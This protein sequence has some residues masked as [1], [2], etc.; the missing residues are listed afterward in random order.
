MKD[1]ELKLLDYG[2]FPQDPVIPTL[3]VMERS[4]Q[5]HLGVELIE[6]LVAEKDYKNAKKV[7]W[8]LF[9]SFNNDSYVL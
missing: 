4:R 6:K 1:K 2:F 3:E 8:W 5:E 7:G 9:K